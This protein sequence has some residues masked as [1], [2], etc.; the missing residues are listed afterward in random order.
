M[1]MYKGNLEHMPPNE[2][3]RWFL[4]GLESARASYVKALADLHQ[5]IALCDRSAADSISAE[6]TGAA[7]YTATR[8]LTHAGEVYDM[9][10]LVLTDYWRTS[11]ERL[12]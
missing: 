1:L 10:L 8:N 7:L 9:A 6:T 12:V 5:T 3:E 2:T 11:K 4:V